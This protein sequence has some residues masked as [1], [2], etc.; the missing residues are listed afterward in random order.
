[1]YPCSNFITGV[2]K[3]KFLKTNIYLI[4]THTK[5]NCRYYANSA[6]KWTFRRIS[7]EFYTY[8][9][10]ANNCSEIT[11][12]RVNINRRP[13]EE[14]PPDIH[15]KIVQGKFV[16]PRL[17]TT[18]NRKGRKE[19]RGILQEE[20]LMRCAFS[21][22]SGNS[23]DGSGDFFHVSYISVA[24]ISSRAIGGVRS[25]LAWL[26]FDYISSVKRKAC[27]K[28]NF[29]WRDRLLSPVSMQLQT[30]GRRL[31]CS[32]W[33]SNRAAVG[34]M[35]LRISVIWNCISP[36]FS[37]IPLVSHFFRSAQIMQRHLTDCLHAAR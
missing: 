34:S 29:P 35:Y 17:N 19:E 24:R 10:V 30:V 25:P 37:I 21:I 27:T 23:G 31:H 15:G 26:Y 32:R 28:L 5:N 4:I 6:F 1:M 13:E 16:F 11:K 7:D 36:L 14:T 20:S 9:S 18:G 33:F 3:I 12:Q 2:P 22:S 8:L